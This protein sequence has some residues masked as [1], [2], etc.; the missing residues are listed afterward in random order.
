M[1]LRATYASPSISFLR[2]Q[3]VFNRS[4]HVHVL[5]HF[6]VIACHFYNVIECAMSGFEAS[7]VRPTPPGALW[8]DDARTA[9]P[10]DDAVEPR[11]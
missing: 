1:Q 9:P 2:K 7:F 10:D 11:S 8:S 5:G 6:H 3:L 4:K